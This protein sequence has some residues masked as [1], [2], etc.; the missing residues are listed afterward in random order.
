MRRLWRSPGDQLELGNT[1]HDTY[2]KYSVQ[3]RTSV[4]SVE[5]SNGTVHSAAVL[6]WILSAG[7]KQPSHIRFLHCDLLVNVCFVFLNL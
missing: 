5:D 4:A 6:I 1:K 7:L 3:V 2:L